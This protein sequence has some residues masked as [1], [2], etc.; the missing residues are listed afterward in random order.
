MMRTLATGVVAT[1][2]I[3]SCGPSSTG[4]KDP[5]SI[6]VQPA[7]ATITMGTTAGAPIDYVAIGHFADG[8]TEMLDAATFAIDPN[9]QALGTLSAAEFTASGMAA[10]TGTVSASSGSVTG[11]TGVSVVVHQ[12]HI[13]P[14]APPGSDGN[15]PDQPG[16]GVN[17]PTIDY[18]LDGAIMPITAAAPD[19]QWEGT[20]NVGDLFRVQIV[21]G[22]A[23]VD[24]IL[25]VTPGFTLDSLPIAADWTLLTAS[26][27]GQ[28]IIVHVD[29]WDAA[30]GAQRGPGVN[31]K[32]INAQVTGVIYYWD[33][34][35]GQ[36]Q[37]ID[38]AGRALAI[39]NPPPLSNVSGNP[40]DAGNHCVACHVVSRDGRYLA[41]EL[42]GGG[43]QGAVFDLSDPAIVTSNPAPT[44]APVTA[45]SYTSLF[46]TFNADGTRLMINPGSGLQVVDPHAG[47]TVATSGAPL[48]T[49]NAAHPS[50]SPDGN[51]VAFI[52]NISNG[53]G[54]A[55]WA[56]D[57]DRGD[58]SVIPVIG[59]DSFG[60]PV[61]LVPAS[62]VDPAFAA[63]SW[64]SFTPDSAYIA[65][66]AGVNSRGRNKVGT[67]EV[68]YPGSLFLVQGTG[69]AA[70]T[71]LDVAC[72]G[73]RD[74]YLPNFSPYDDGG[75]VWLVFY[76]LR[77]YGNTL[78][79]TKGT[80]RRQMW[81]TAIDKSKLGTG[82]DPSSVPYWLPLQDSKT[83]NMSAFWAV[84][85]PPQ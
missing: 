62:S 48:P 39:P 28:P 45:S 33:L 2:L 24:T 55:A 26:A 8:H 61:T 15:F 11:S 49:A 42:W 85:P 57:Y 65:Y 81:V 21:A 83:D 35:Q 1:L 64:P 9:A 82:V 56:V 18:P 4:G 22:L 50:W 29:H 75:Y 69:G 40:A 84:P 31:V 23:T 51:S 52:N 6:E 20:A 77:D 19:V 60:V 47:A 41:G 73:A 70:P 12:T 32:A 58:V 80:Q 71:R 46:Q 44:L 3:A 53:G 38:G 74:C 63:P 17:A 68:A 36:M 78:A 79:G 16:P 59:P 66:G 14:M 7:N 76:S 10:G 5:D 67:T 13:D 34:S 72:G 25:A 54:A 37:R 27:H 30:T 43:S